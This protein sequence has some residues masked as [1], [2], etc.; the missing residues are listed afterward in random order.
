MSERV[1][2][3]F[4]A[5]SSSHRKHALMLLY[6]NDLLCCEKL[7]QALFPVGRD[8]RAVHLSFFLSTDRASL[9]KRCFLAI[10]VYRNPRPLQPAGLRVPGHFIDVSDHTLASLR[11]YRLGLSLDACNPRAIARIAGDDQTVRARL[12]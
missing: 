6:I 4:I 12:A 7:A 9:A 8:H 5:S 10:F 11:P 2:P 3:R 1:R